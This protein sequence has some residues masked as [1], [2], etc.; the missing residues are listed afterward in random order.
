LAISVCKILRHYALP[1]YADLI[2]RHNGVALITKVLC[3][4]AVD[5]EAARTALNAVVALAQL[6][7]ASD[8][9]IRHDSWGA[10]I[11][12]LGVHRHD[13]KAVKTFCTAVL[14]LIIHKHSPAGLLDAFLV[15]M[16]VLAI[17]SADTETV[18]GVLNTC[19]SISGKLAH[20]GAVAPELAWIPLLTRLLRENIADI[21]M[22]LHISITMF[23]IRKSGKERDNALQYEIEQAV[24]VLC[25]ALVLHFAAEHCG[26]SICNAIADLQGIYLHPLCSTFRKS[27]NCGVAKHHKHACPACGGCGCCSSLTETS[28]RFFINVHRWKC[29]GQP[30]VAA[31][32]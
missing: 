4:Y 16:Q 12:A 3:D 26:F 17:H 27:N 30:F 29:I 21:E 2:L 24:A 19:N 7:G 20:E 9:V 8:A 22:V 32:R 6:P 5:L 23:C 11:Q 14:S 31:C 25:D 13:G 28:E 10:V 18:R 1:E 15:V